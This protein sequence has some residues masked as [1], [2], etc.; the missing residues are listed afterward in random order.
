MQYKCNKCNEEKPWTDFYIC[1][2]DGVPRRKNSCK[3]CFNIAKDRTAMRRRFIE[4]TENVKFKRYEK[5]KELE[6]NNHFGA[7]NEGDIYN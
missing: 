4:L 1:K 5:F 3:R 2:T 6:P 7:L